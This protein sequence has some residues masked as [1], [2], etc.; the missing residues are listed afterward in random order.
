MLEPGSGAELSIALVN[1]V[2]IASWAL[3]GLLLCYVRQS[4]AVRRIR[5]EF[6]LRKSEAIELDRAAQLYKDVHGRLKEIV[7]QS[8]KP[9]KL[10]RVLF[11]SLA[12]SH[13]KNA[14]EFDDLEAYAQHLRSTI[15]QLKRRPLNRLKSWARKKTA[16][17]TLGGAIAT[18]VLSLAF[19]IV[20]LYG[21]DQPAWGEQLTTHVKNLIIWYPFDERLY[22]ANAVAA[23]FTAIAAP[24]FYLLRRVGLQREYE[25]E[26]WILKGLANIDLGQLVHQRQ[27]DQREQGPSPHEASNEMDQ[28]DACFVVLG[29]S[30]A[31]SLEDVKAAYKALIKQNHPDRVH[32]MSPAFSK[33]AEAETKRL[34][35]AYERAL[36]SVSAHN[37]ECSL[38]KY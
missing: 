6:S 20:V 1:A 7:N 34:N 27:A 14:D 36:V 16:Q 23:G 25:L 37:S 4:L 33:L 13:G 28:G 12:A 9:N 10:W 38:V 19:L 2:L 29:L 5:P 31:A 17:F 35:A 11:G 30:D 24:A 26:F 22:C 32:G 21:H 3:P 15:I 8:R 18:H